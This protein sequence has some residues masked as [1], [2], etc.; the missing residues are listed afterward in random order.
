MKI[1]RLPSGSMIKNSNTVT[2]II[3]VII[4]SKSEKRAGQPDRVITHTLWLSGC[5]QVTQLAYTQILQGQLHAVPALI[6]R[7]PNAGNNAA[8]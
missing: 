1:G 5:S 7:S 3:S 8:A 2:E 6:G 4:T